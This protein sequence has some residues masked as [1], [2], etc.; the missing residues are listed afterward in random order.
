[1]HQDL[2]VVVSNNPTWGLLRGL[3]MGGIKAAYP[4]TSPVLTDNPGQVIANEVT[5]RI[6]AQSF[7]LLNVAPACITATIAGANDNWNIQ[8]LPVTYDPGAS[9]PPSTPTG[10]NLDQYPAYLVMLPA[11]KHFEVV[12]F[13]FICD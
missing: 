10:D 5:I 1:M 4:G 8:S 2:T 6:P 7:L 9:T 3:Q 13:D 12:H 11:F